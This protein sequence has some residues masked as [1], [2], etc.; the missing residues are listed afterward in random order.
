MVVPVSVD[1]SFSY[2]EKARGME[3]MVKQVAE[4]A[5]RVA[6]AGSW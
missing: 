2:T 1:M 5:V 4:E 3:A 6:E